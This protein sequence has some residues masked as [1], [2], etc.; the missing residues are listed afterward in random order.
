MR[1]YREGGDMH[2]PIYDP[3]TAPLI[4]NLIKPDDSLCGQPGKWHIIWNAD[5]DNGV[6]CDE[7]VAFAR[8]YAYVGCHTML[9]DCFMPGGVWLADKDICVI[10][11]SGLGLPELEMAHALGIDGSGQEAT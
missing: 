7:H 3:P 10:D 4:C 2:P 8:K 1:V 11:E 5:L 9:P 6:A